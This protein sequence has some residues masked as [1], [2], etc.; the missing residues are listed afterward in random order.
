[1]KRSTLQELES[2]VTKAVDS[3]NWELL[4]VRYHKLRLN[5]LKEMWEMFGHDLG[6][7]E[8]EP[9]LEQTVLDNV[10]DL[11]IRKHTKDAKSSGD[12]GPSSSQTTESTLSDVE[13]IL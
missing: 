7:G 4:W 13:N 12:S 2:L 10:L 9:I 6:L 5:K 1:M 3:R 11:L 8:L